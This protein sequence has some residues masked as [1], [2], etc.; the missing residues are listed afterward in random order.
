[1][2]QSIA[3][4]ILFAVEDDAGG[5]GGDL[6][7]VDIVAVAVGFHVGHGSAGPADFSDSGRTPEVDTDIAPHPVV[8]EVDG[9]VG[10]L[11]AAAVTDAIHIIVT[12]SGAIGSAAGG[13]V[14]GFGAGGSNPSMTIGST[15]G[16]L[17]NGAGLG[18][19]TG[20]GL[21]IVAQRSAR[22]AAAAITGLRSGAG[23][24]LVIVTQLGTGGCAAGGTGLGSGASGIGV[25]V[26]QSGAGGCTTGCTGLGSG[27]GCVLP[28]VAV[29]STGGCATN[30]TGFCCSTG[31]NV[32]LMA[33]GSDGC[34]VD[35]SAI[36]AGLLLGAGLC[37]SSFLCHGVASVVVTG[38]ICGD[39]VGQATGGAGFHGSTSGGTSSSVNDC[40]AHLAVRAGALIHSRLDYGEVM[41]QQRSGRIGQLSS[42][43][44]TG[45]VAVIPCGDDVGVLT[46]GKVLNG[47]GIGNG[48]VS[49]FVVVIDDGVDTAGY[50]RAASA[51][52]GVDI[53]TGLG[54][55][56]IGGCDGAGNIKGFSGYNGLGCGVVIQLDIIV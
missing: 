55:G 51:E 3:S 31:C 29:G 24:R 21:P 20:C 19:G 39:L 34:S 45:V 14:L 52:A 32:P 6:S 38:L 7:G 17:T 16:D 46:G 23:G 10:R 12:Q 5:I 8:L 26:T 28:I 43:C 13:T 37:T 44:I 50:L 48:A 41:L 1:M 4:V 56:R 18:S 2:I 47:G 9:D 25:A 11:L 53:Y 33:G 42:L 36:G 15:C 27:A 22:G 49:Q 30:S 54:D 35:L 40:G